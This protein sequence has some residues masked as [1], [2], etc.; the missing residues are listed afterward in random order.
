MFKWNGRVWVCEE[1][2][3]KWLRKAL[4]QKKIWALD[5]P[6]IVELYLNEYNMDK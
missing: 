4:K 1:L 2:L 5:M 3:D 6:F